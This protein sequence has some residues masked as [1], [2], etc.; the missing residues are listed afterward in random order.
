MKKCTYCGQENHDEA[1]ACSGCGTEFFVPKK[2]PEP[3]V[4]PEAQLLQRAGWAGRDMMALA[5]CTTLAML[6]QWIGLKE[7]TALWLVV[8]L[9][10]GVAAVGY[11]LLA[12]AARRGDPNAVAIVL[13]IILAQLTLIFIGAGVA[14]AIKHNAVQQWKTALLL[15]KGPKPNRE[16]AFAA[17]KQGDKFRTEAGQEF[18]RQY[19]ASKGQ[20]SP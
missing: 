19:K 8:P 6:T 3:K 18:A 2:N 20:S 12:V 7:V 15:L 11:W 1:G 16:R 9:M 13:V 14:A 5:V 10:T 4:V 17:F